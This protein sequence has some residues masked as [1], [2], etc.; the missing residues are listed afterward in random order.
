MDVCM[1]GAPVCV[2]RRTP[3]GECGPRPRP[4]DAHTADL[5]SDGSA[6]RNRAVTSRTLRSPPTRSHPIPRAFDD[7][8]LH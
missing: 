3:W 4:C 1:C 5:E 6:S 8:A 2:P 7:Y